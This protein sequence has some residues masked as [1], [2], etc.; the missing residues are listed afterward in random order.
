MG[1]KQAMA[2]IIFQ[3]LFAFMNIAF[4]NDLENSVAGFRLLGAI[5]ILCSCLLYI[6][7]I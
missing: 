4:K 3:W 7:M 5:V 6:K 2:V 1:I